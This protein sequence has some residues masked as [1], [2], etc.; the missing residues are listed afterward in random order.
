M[1]YM[2]KI[3]TTKMIKMKTKIYTVILLSIVISVILFY[4]YVLSDYLIT[5]L[6]AF[7]AGLVLQPVIKIIEEKSE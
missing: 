2:V 1:P 4:S 6:F 3:R 5:I 7:I